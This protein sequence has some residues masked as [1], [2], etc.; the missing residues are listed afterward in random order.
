M[1]KFKRIKVYSFF[2]DNIWGVDLADIQ[3]LSKYNKRIEYLL[4]P[5]DL[6]SKHAWVVPLKDKRGI[7]IVNAFQ[8]VSKRRKPN[9]IWVNQSSEFYNNLFERILK[10]DDIEMCST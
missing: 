2:R 4:H 7:T 9:K 10:I 5:T 8:K 6:F 3:S 1:L